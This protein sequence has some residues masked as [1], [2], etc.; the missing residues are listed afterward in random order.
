[1]A[2]IVLFGAAL[3]FLVA[4]GAPEPVSAQTPRPI[5]FDS[6]CPAPVRVLLSGTRSNGETYVQGWYAIP[7]GDLQRGSS[8]ALK[9]T[10]AEAQFEHD[11]AQPLYVYAETTSGTPRVLSGDTIRA[12]GGRQYGF[13]RATVA[14]V[15]STGRFEIHTECRST[16]DAPA[17]GGNVTAVRPPQPVRSGQPA[18]T[19]YTGACDP[20]SP[21]GAADFIC[22]AIGNR[23]RGQLRQSYASDT[24]IHRDFVRF[25]G[26]SGECVRLTAS[27]GG[28]DLKDQYTLRLVWSRLRPWH[29]RETAEWTESTFPEG[30]RI[31]GSASTGWS[32]WHEWRLT[33]TG[34][35]RAVV[36]SGNRQ[37][38]L[39]LSRCQ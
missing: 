5:F 38:E 29:G 10:P 12:Y 6:H 26:R 25:F 17:A 1:V 33:E 19:S 30:G 32:S 22:M 31:A 24:F 27:T 20:R 37:V 13:A 34:W 28:F 18:A 9:R 3:A 11:P 15:A 23:F 4:V 16:A 14:P 21:T 35:H 8:I 39:S 36:W 2:K 7:A